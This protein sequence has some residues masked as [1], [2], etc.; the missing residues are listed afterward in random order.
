[1]NA[2]AIRGGL[3]ESL[4]THGES[5]AFVGAFAS[6]IEPG[7]FGILRDVGWDEEDLADLEDGVLQEGLDALE[8]EREE[9]A[10][11]ERIQSPGSATLVSHGE[12]GEGVSAV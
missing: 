6:H 1:M 9:A 12:A 5:L 10:R 2:R 4:P 11:E 3:S 8:G 7:E